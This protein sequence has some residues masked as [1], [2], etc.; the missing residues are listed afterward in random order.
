MFML[1]NFVG[2]SINELGLADEF[3][4]FVQWIEPF[5]SKVMTIVT[6]FAG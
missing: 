1:F 5:I 4:Y 2:W 6:T 3:V